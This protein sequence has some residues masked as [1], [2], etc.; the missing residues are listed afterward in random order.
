M[1]CGTTIFFLSAAMLIPGTM[2]ISIMGGGTVLQDISTPKG[3]HDPLIP[4]WLGC[5]IVAGGVTVNVFFGGM[6]GTW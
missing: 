4:Y 2:I 5:G 6:R 3:A 1:P